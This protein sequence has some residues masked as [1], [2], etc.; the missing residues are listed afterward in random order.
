MV[1]AHVADLVQEQR[2]AVRRLKKSLAIFV[3]AGERALH[4]AEQFGFQQRLRKRAAID[5]DE[6]RLRAGA[7]FVDGAGDQFLAGAALAG[8]QHAAGLRRD[9]HDH[10]EDR[11]HFGA[12]ADDIV[13]AG[14]AAQFAAQVTG[15]FLQLQGLVHLR[16]ARRN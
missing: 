13:L 8:D 11:A 6:R 5:G 15:L 1:E 14:Q 9:G 7:I 4:V 3:R 2:A 12:V 16:T 10:V